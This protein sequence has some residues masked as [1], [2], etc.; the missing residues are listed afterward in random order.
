MPP[1]A[2][3][4]AA[5][6]VPLASPSSP[7]APCTASTCPRIS[8]AASASSAAQAGRQADEDALGE[9]RGDL[10]QGRR[11]RA[12]HVA[13]AQGADQGGQGL[14][15]VADVRVQ[16]GAVGEDPHHHGQRVREFGEQAALGE[17]P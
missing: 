13:V 10:A 14:G 5:G 1:R 11:V 17:A 9:P 12:A 15:E 16:G 2:G 3:R 6:R 8:A 4:S 7:T